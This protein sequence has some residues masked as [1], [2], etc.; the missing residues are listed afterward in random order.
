MRSPPSCRR[1]LSPTHFQASRRW[2]QRPRLRAVSADLF[3]TRWIEDSGSRSTHSPRSRE[4]DGLLGVGR[5]LLHTRATASTASPVDRQR[6]TSPRPPTRAHR[7]AADALLT[8]LE[9]GAE[10][11][12]YGAR[13]L[14][15]ALVPRRAGP[16]H[17]DRRVVCTSHEDLAHTWPLDGRACIPIVRAGSSRRAAL[18]ATHPKPTHSSVTLRRADGVGHIVVHAVLR[19]G[20]HP[21]CL[22]VKPSLKLGL[23]VPNPP[24]GTV[25]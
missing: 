18:L 1:P 24:A 5:T 20:N 13:A 11:A 9:F 17:A 6:S 14:G 10:V 16:Q 8:A 3:K 23:A 15:G 12:R 22:C 2:T 4:Y 25:T 21:L 19:R 7:M